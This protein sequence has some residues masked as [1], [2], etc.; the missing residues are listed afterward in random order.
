[1]NSQFGLDFGGD[2]RTDRTAAASLAPSGTWNHGNFDLGQFR[3]QLHLAGR[4][5]NTVPDEVLGVFSAGVAEGIAQLAALDEAGEN[6]SVRVFVGALRS[7][8][9]DA[10]ESAVE[11][12]RRY[13]KQHASSPGSSDRPKLKVQ[14]SFSQQCYAIYVAG[15]GSVVYATYSAHGT[16]SLRFHANV[17]PVLFPSYRDDMETLELPWA[18][19]GAPAA[20][21]NSDLSGK[22]T[23]CSRP[24]AIGG[25]LFV[26]SGTIYMGRSDLAIGHAW[27]LRAAVD[28]VDQ[29]YSYS[30]LTALWDNGESQRGDMRGLIVDVA[31]KRYIVDRALEVYDPKGR[32]ASTAAAERAASEPQTEDDESGDEAVNE[33]DLAE[34]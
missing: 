3:A 5:L 6:A 25:R 24:F 17:A 20:R 2:D 19:W 34:A 32:I 4:N 8:D 9:F 22:A 11:S 13:C 15:V 30:D 12:F 27:R 16:V 23:T 21:I 7:L 1:M 28:W 18:L 29:Q 10:D 31:G 33:F 14:E 26:S